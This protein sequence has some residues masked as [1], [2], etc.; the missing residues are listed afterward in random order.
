MSIFDSVK[1]KIEKALKS[2][3]SKIE[4]GIKSTGHQIEGEIKHVGT[5]I[6]HQIKHVGT[7][8][9]HELRE[10]GDEIADGL[11]KGFGDLI[12]LAEQGVLGEAL[13]KIADAAEKEIFEGDAPIPLK[14]AFIDIEITDAKALARV[15]RRMIEDGLPTSKSQWRHIIIELA[16]KAITIKPG[17]PLIAQLCK[18]IDLEGLEA[19]ALDAALR[20]AGLD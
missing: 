18:R 14:T 17:V 9:E 7:D 6:E 11:T 3:G 16:P 13:D 20:K 8:I 1:H 5:D 10:I 12:A 4:K 15:I 19:S 2:L